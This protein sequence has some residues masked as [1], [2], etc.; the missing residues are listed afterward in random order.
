MKHPLLT[1]AAFIGIHYIAL[2]Q[3]PVPTIDQQR[4]FT[5]EIMLPTTPVKSQ[6]NTGTCWGFAT[7]SFIESELMRNG[8][9]P[10]D[11]S[12]M[13]IVWQVYMKKAEDYIRWEGKMNFGQG[14]LSHD[15][16]TA[17]QQAGL[18]PQDVFEG[19]RMDS[20]FDHT[21]LETVSKAFLDALL[22]TDS[23]LSPYWKQ[24]YAGILDAYI[25]TRPQSFTYRNKSFTPTEF[26]ERELRFNADDYIEITSFTHHAFYK[27]FVLEIPDNFAKALYYNVPIDE[28]EEIADHALRNGYSVTWDGDVSE[29]GFRART[30]IADV[31]APEEVTRMKTKQL[32][33]QRQRSFDSKETTDD[34]LMHITGLATGLNGRTFY[35]IKNSWGSDLGEGGYLYMSK[36]YFRLKTIAIMVHKDALPKSIA[37]KLGLS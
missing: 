31:E 32:Q 8:K 29:Q 22:S 26:A 15:Q 20:T 11:L 21:E 4:A 6:D 14:G 36:E 2:S 7:T 23:E 30:G 34:H 9:E 28:F 17:V 10:I 19:N 18:M 35:L 33:Q 5:N 3:E 13:Y 25:G 27:P 12:E 1:L 37:K 24:A 16:I